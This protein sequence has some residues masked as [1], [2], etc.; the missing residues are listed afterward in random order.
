MQKLPA[1]VYVIASVGFLSALGIGVIAPILPTLG[2]F[3]GVGTT[4][5]SMAI[6]GLAAARLAANLV[7]ARY[8]DRWSLT[9]VLGLGLLL[10]GGGNGRRWG[11]SR[12]WSFYRAEVRC[13]YW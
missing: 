10:Q 6:S 5:M 2:H 12:L 9:W 7:F 1:P 8:L 13:W 3:F 11:K 4:A